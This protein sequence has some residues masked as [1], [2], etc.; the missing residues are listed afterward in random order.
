MVGV[1]KRLMIPAVYSALPA[2][3]QASVQAAAPEPV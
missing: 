2:E 3:S 1:R